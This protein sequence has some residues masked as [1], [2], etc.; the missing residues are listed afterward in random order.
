MM[1]ALAGLHA[2]TLDLL[3]YSVLAA[4]FALNLGIGWWSARKSQ[5]SSDDFLRGGGRTAWWAAGISF[6]A[7]GSSSISTMAIPAT[8]YSGNWLSFGSAPAQAAATVIIAFAFVSLLRRLNITTIFEYLEFRFNRPVRLLGAI[9][10]LL[11]KVFG[12]VSVV[13]L[14]PSLA[15]SEVTGLSVY[16]SIF[17]LGGVTVVYAGAGGLKAVIWTDVAQTLI[18][19]G[20]LAFV[21]LYISF[22]VPHGISG[23]LHLA[24][25]RGKL[26]PVSWDWNF[27]EPTFCVF[28]GMGLASVFQQLSDQP[29]M[30]KV[31]STP[32]PRAARNSVLLGVGI[33]L[34]T[35][36]FFFFLGTALFAFYQVHP[37]RLSSP[38][39]PDSIVP[40]FIIHELPHGIVGMIVA[41][42]FA[43]AMGTIS[44]IIN[45][46]ATIA[47]TDCFDLLFPDAGESQKVT[48]ARWVTI[49]AGVSGMAMAAYI[50]SQNVHSLWD[51]YLKL[52]ALLG[53]GLPGVF[54]LG[55]LSRRANS[56]GVIAGLVASI[57]VTWYVQAFTNVSSFLHGFIAVATSIVIGYGASRLVTPGGRARDLAGLTVWDPKTSPPRTARLRT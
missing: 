39:T 44:S 5:S 50:A 9:L 1:L 54:A 52:I 37:G 26:H 4:F 42:I 35:S 46:T 13:M 49:A 48:F 34:P 56:V 47:K 32:N 23:I 36:V 3:D 7:T 40:Y 10:T 29:L 17:L 19:F 57:A 8:T 33:A 2:Q 28:V 15:L 41:G 24:A 43:S 55:L 22:G 45:S 18:V 16:W 11:L 12:R 30:Q 20:G 25:A 14:L 31:F 51:H 38:A 21:I 53:G 6:F 27:H